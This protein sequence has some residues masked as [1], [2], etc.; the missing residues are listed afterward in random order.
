MSAPMTVR[1]VLSTDWGWPEGPS[2]REQQMWQ[3]HAHA[4]VVGFCP[5]EA[6]VVTRLSPEPHDSVRVSNVRRAQLA[7]AWVEDQ[8]Q[9]EWERWVR[10]L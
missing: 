4:F 9:E 8:L 7:P 6:E 10:T 1:V 5:P 2:L 3:A